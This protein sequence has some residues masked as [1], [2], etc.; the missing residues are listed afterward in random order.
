MRLLTNV[1]KSI[2]S[3]AVGNFWKNHP[4]AESWWSTSLRKLPAKRK[5]DE[6]IHHP[7]QRFHCCESHT[8]RRVHFLAEGRHPSL[9]LCSWAVIYL[10]GG[11]VGHLKTFS[12]LLVDR[13]VLWRRS[14]P[15]DSSE[16]FFFDQISELKRWNGYIDMRCGDSVGRLKNFGALHFCWGSRRLEINGAVLKYQRGNIWSKPE[17]SAWKFLCV[18]SLAAFTWK[19][20]SSLDGCVIH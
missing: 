17:I 12:Q 10:L 7:A 4:A 8:Y 20:D 9:H 6:L 15:W 11:R 13:T 2:F 19:S 5:E 1:C 3:F 14:E 16:F 18:T